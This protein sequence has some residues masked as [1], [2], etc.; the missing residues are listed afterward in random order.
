MNCLCADSRVV[1]IVSREIP[2]A[3]VNANSWNDECSLAA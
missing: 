1:E 2:L 3:A